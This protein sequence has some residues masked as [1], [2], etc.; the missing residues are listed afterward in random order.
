MNLKILRARSLVAVVAVLVVAVSAALPL[1]Q[2]AACP[3]QGVPITTSWT[4][5]SNCTYSTAGENGIVLGANG[6][7]L[8]CKGHTITYSVS[9][10]ND[11]IIVLSGYT[12]DTIKNCVVVSPTSGLGIGAFAVSGL[13]LAGNTVVGATDYAFKIAWASNVVLTGNTASSCTNEGFYLDY[14]FNLVMSGNTASCYNGFDLQNGQ[15]GILTGN[16][17][18]G[19]TEYGFYFDNTQYTLKSNKAD[20]NAYGYY[21]DTVGPGTIGLGNTYVNNECSGNTSDGSYDAYASFGPAFLC[22][23]QG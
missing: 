4:L 15:G 10:V 17:A 18:T 20:S 11:P 12:G 1:S 21:D 23:P 6:I 16:K 14:V 8:D 13:T 2:A 3:T 5:T 19:N 22:T 9:T 7:T